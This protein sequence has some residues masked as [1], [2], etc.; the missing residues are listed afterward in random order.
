MKNMLML[1]I[2]T[3]RAFAAAGPGG[4]AGCHSAALA[5]SSTYPGC[6]VVFN[7]T[8]SIAWTL[9]DVVM[10]CS[11]AAVVLSALRHFYNAEHSSFI[12]DRWG[13]ALS[14]ALVWP[15]DP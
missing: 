6:A 7:K 1:G 2:V 11:G 13:C 12:L 9:N 15:G 4:N 5:M 10:I 3:P 8:G 14:T